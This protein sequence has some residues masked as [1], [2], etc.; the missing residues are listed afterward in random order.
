[1][2]R[3]NVMVSNRGKE[4]LLRYQI[5]NKIKSKDDALDGI[6][7]ELSDRQQKKDKD[8]KVIIA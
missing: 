2:Q 7:L 6:L 3:I 4:A 5:E 1:M 8:K